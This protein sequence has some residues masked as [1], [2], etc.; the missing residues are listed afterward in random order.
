MLVEWSCT[1]Q[2]AIPPLNMNHI[3]IIIEILRILS[4]YFNTFV[5]TPVLALQHGNSQK[6]CAS[7]LPMKESNVVSIPFVP[8]TSYR[9]LLKTKIT[10][11]ARLPSRT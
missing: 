6:L 7:K 11:I 9:T 1:L 4:A 3:G 10:Y 2:R 5:D 8:R